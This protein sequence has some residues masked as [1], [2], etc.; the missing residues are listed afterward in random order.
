MFSETQYDEIFEARVAYKILPIKKCI[1]LNAI[2]N[3][4]E[5]CSAKHYC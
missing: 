2:P 4:L 5:R 1:F 3:D